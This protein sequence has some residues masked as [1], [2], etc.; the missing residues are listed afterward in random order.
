MSDNNELIELCRAMIRT[1]SYSGHEDGMVRLIL[2]FMNE[3]GF[4]EAFTDKYGNVLGCIRGRRPGKRI[5]FDGHIDTV[6]VDNPGDW[7]HDPF[8]AEITDG[9]IYGRG[10][11]DMKGADAAM[12]WS[13]ARFAEQTDRDFAGELWFAGVVHEE[14]FEGISARII[15]ERIR[16]DLVVI[17]EASEMNVKCS[18]RGRAEILLETF[19][20]PC[21]SS[22][23]DKGIN[24]VYSMMKLLERVR[25][26][27]P[28]EQPGMFG[29]GIMELTDIKSEPYPGASVVPHYC[30]VTFDRRLLVG[31]TRESVLAPIQRI[32][33]ELSAGSAV[34]SGSGTAPGQPEFR[35]GVSFTKGSEKCYTGETIAADRFF[36]AWRVDTG[37]DYVQAI[38]G[39]ILQ[40]NCA[41]VY[42]P[43]LTGYSFCTNGSHYGGEAG[44]PCIGIGPSREALAHTIDE[45]V[46]IA[47]LTDICEYYT[48]VAE[49][50]TL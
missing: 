14:C 47:E 43:Q 27:A 18:Q 33:D 32:I 42:K 31:E 30:R 41:A 11:T 39:R 40:K 37:A 23:P 20:V 45:Y 1:Q 10:T 50:M 12:L 4:D 16:P 5:L 6:P 19:G 25:Q 13:I 26:I 7:H 3:K 2:D 29:K 8:G 9:R 24:A 48:A 22:N 35:A 21:H 44:I 28:I 15:S 38:Y 36:P 49:S 17:G 46:E 34:R